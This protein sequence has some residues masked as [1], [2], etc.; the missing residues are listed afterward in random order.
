M[1]AE[2]R[3]FVVAGGNEKFVK[4]QVEKKCEDHK[5]EHGHGGYT[6]SWAE[7]NGGLEFHS[8][9]FKS[10]EL[11]YQYF[12][13]TWPEKGSKKAFIPGVVQKW[14]NAIAVQFRNEKGQLNWLVGA[15]F[16]C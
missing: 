8:K 6:G 4:Q 9:V 11:A 3:A 5:H 14:E 12:F 15:C 10:R 2:D 7:W 13:G 16:S 1:G